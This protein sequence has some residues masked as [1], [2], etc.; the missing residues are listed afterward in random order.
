M[1]QMIFNIFGG[2]AIF[3]FGMKMMS[4]GLHV[5]AG[6]K[7]RMVLRLFSA[8]RFVAI[9]SGT[10]VTAVIQSSSASTVMVIGFVNAGLLNLVQAIGIIFGANIGTTVTAQL[11]A[12]DISWIIMPAILLGLLL[13][14]I[15]NARWSG[16]GT[17]VIGL[18]FLFLG[19]QF[20]SIE[21][22]EFSHHPGFMAAFQ[23]FQCAPVAGVIPPV[24]LFGAIGVGLLA[25]LIIQSSSACTGIII[26]LGAGGIIDLYTAV[27]LVLGSN[28]GT[29]VTAQLASIPANRV[30]KQAALAHT[31]FNTIGVLVMVGTFWFTWDG[32]PVF[33]RLIDTLSGD[34]TLPRKIA[35]AHT[36]FNICTTLLLLPFI[37]L[38]ATVCRRIIPER[39]SKIKYQRLELH[40]LDTP[41]IALVQT[42][43]ALRK[44]LKKAWEMVDCALTYRDRDDDA[45]RKMKK[46]LD[47]MENRIDER[48]QEITDYL[49]QLMQRP[50]FPD[51][52][53]Q[54]P[55]LLHCTNDAERIG[56]HTAIIMDVM[57]KL[58]L[59]KTEISPEAEQEFSSLRALLAKQSKCAISLLE[60]RTPELI[61]SAAQLKYEIVTSVDAG[62]NAHFE[63]IR[64]GKCRPDIGI[65]Y[66]QLLEEVRKLSRH[67]ANITDRA[68]SLYEPIPKAGK[69]L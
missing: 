13:G 25:T 54:I 4:D 61:A 66:L 23:M 44:M 45:N 58:R 10:A 40:L 31:L 15:P 60:K 20:M 57:T 56:D 32:I 33:F 19:M 24:A 21:L 47:E 53:R 18:G 17:A 37:P 48:Q 8:N 6:E 30:A 46:N 55:L 29:T 5:V 68:E 34:G 64:A 26:A 69:Q 63:R 67:L 65:L 14:F 43:S 59:Q 28:I 36:V 42:S 12:F 50:L 62:E 9:L 3:I 51:Q 39:E 49:S 1:L 27:A 11:V 38:L 7:M 22:M 52:A 2:L 16:W 35:N 41:S